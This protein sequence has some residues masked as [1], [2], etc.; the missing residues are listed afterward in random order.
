VTL[1]FAQIGPG[2]ARIRDRRS[3]PFLQSEF[4]QSA[5][6]AHTTYRVKT[7]KEGAPVDF[8]RR[9]IWRARCSGAKARLLSRSFSWGLSPTLPPQS[10]REWLGHAKQLRRAW[11][12]MPLRRSRERGKRHGASR[13]RCTRPKVSDARFEI[14]PSF[15]CTPARPDRGCRI[16]F[17][18]ATRR[19]PGR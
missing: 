14:S 4:S 10:S 11:H 7:K 3:A 9:G 16:L 12:A 15:R 2:R 19:R 5:H 17:R 1:R 8:L 6:R 18:A 13:R